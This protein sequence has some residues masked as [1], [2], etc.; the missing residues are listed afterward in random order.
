MAAR[1][2]RAEWGAWGPGNITFILGHGGRR[3]RA[4]TPTL[5]RAAAAAA[6]PRGVRGDAWSPALPSGRERPVAC[7]DESRD[8]A[9]PRPALPTHGR[10]QMASHL[11]ALLFSASDAA[12]PRPLSSLRRRGG[13]TPPL[14]LKLSDARSA[15]C[16]RNM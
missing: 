5:T 9:L 6:P 15:E 13:L 10:Q 2:G 4:A 14:L 11:L 1:P 16:S 12:R 7:A 8:R 3:G